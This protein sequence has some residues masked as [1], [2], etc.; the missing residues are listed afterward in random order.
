MIIVRNEVKCNW[1]QLILQNKNRRIL[2]LFSYALKH[3]LEKVKA[4]PLRAELPTTLKI[5]LVDLN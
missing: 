3:L 4:R 5:L 1:I 2:T